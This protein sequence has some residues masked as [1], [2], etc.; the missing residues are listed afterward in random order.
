MYLE[1]H[2]PCQWVRGTHLDSRDGDVEEAT[3]VAHD[4]PVQDPNYIHGYHLVRL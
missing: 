1:N 4:Q 3:K 2:S